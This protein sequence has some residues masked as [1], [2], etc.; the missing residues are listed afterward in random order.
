MCILNLTESTT[1]LGI[2]YTFSYSV[3]QNKDTKIGN[4]VTNNVLSIKQISFVLI[5]NVQ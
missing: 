3:L 2:L 4:V 5:Q 1:F